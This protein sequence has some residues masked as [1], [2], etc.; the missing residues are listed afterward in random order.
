MEKLNKLSVGNVQLQPKNSKLVYVDD[1]DRVITKVNEI[2]DI[3]TSKVY[4]VFLTQAGTAAPTSSVLIDT[5]AP[6]IAYSAVGTYTF[7]KAGA[8][9]SGKTTPGATIV[10][11]I[12]DA[13]NKLTAQWTSV[14]VITLKTYAAVDTAVLAND[15]LSGHEFQINIY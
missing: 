7:T 9:T 4:H 3:S 5:I 15:V 8:F 6:T 2:I 12:D 1:I 11:A 13:G 14:D 10:S